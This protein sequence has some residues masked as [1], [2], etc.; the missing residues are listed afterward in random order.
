M[1]ALCGMRPYTLTTLTLSFIVDMGCFDGVNPPNN[2]Q[3]DIIFN[4]FVMASY[5]TFAKNFEVK[6]VVVVN[7][8]ARMPSLRN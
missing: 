2:N 8:T 5:Y 3:L 7:R 4:S 1:G 6:L